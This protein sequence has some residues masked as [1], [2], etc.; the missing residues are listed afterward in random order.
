[1]TAV[2]V[3]DVVRT[4]DRAQHLVAARRNLVQLLTMGS[5]NLVLE[6][7]PVTKKVTS[8]WTSKFQPGGANMCARLKVQHSVSVYCRSVERFSWDAVLQMGTE[9]QTAR[10]LQHNPR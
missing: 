4:A 7:C 6:P 10:A 1:M 2:C 8:L 5:T 3:A 9:W